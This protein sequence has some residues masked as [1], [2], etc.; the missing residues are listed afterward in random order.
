MAAQVVG[1]ARAF[2]RQALELIDDPGRRGGWDTVVVPLLQSIGWLS[3][4]VAAAVDAVEQ[5]DPKVAG[6]LAGSDARL[7]D[8]GTGTGWLAIELAR[9]HP[10]LTVI[11]I[12]IFDPALDLARNNVAL[13]GLSDRIKLR[14]QDAANLQQPDSYDA[15]WVPLP[16]LTQG[17]RTAG[18]DRCPPQ[19]EAGW[20]P[21]RGDLHRTAGR[22]TPTADRPAHGRSGGH[23]W[24]P[25]QI[26]DL[27]TGAR[28]SSAVE[29]PR[30]WGAPVRLFVGHRP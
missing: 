3:M 7:L 1:L 13:A 19:P 4:G 2:L 18:A 29:V 12:D 27:L 14:H 21:A 15:V 20:L 25:P 23:P 9:R 24:R 5:L 16:F 26:L 28:F 6:R 30:T 10:M 11:G 17:R 8:I 22:P